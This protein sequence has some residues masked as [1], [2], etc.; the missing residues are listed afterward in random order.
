MSLGQK[1]RGIQQGPAGPRQTSQRE[2]QGTP[3]AP[4]PGSHLTCLATPAGFQNSPC[5]QAQPPK[6]GQP[7]GLWVLLAPASTPAAW[8]PGLPLP[9]LPPQ[10]P[11]PPASETTALAHHPSPGRTALCTALPLIALPRQT[12]HHLPG[13]RWAGPQGQDSQQTALRPQGHSL[14]TRQVHLQIEPR[15]FSTCRT[16]T[17]GV[18]DWG[19][20]RKA[21][22][23]PLPTAHPRTHAVV[24]GLSV[25]CP[26]DL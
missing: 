17:L 1:P 3:P 22:V 14:E 10:V 20:C 2:L 12:L 11:C 19:P 7:K 15:L 25:M 5:P 23:V 21:I 8:S 13:G 26:L 9:S 4:A 16:G 24:P 18:G 6:E